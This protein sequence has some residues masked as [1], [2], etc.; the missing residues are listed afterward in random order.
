ME[1]NDDFSAV[2]IT[3]LKVRSDHSW[4]QIEDVMYQDIQM[5]SGGGYNTQIISESYATDPSKGSDEFPVSEIYMSGTCQ[6]QVAVDSSVGAGFELPGFTFEHS[7]GDTYYYHSDPLYL[8]YLY[9][10]Y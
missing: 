4:A 2:L 1:D 8:E 9:T 7:V 3:Q 10:V 6:F 5:S